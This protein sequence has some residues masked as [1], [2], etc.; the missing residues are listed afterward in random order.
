LAELLLLVVPAA[1][2]CKWPLTLVLA[3]PALVCYLAVR[4]T[5]AQGVSIFYC[6]ALPAIWFCTTLVSWEH[7]GDEY[8]LFGVGALPA[9]WAMPFVQF[10]HLR[11]VLPL[12]LAAGVLTM[13]LAGWA[14]DRMRVSLP[15]WANAWVLGV[16]LLTCYAVLQ[17]PSYQR[18]MAK[19]GSLTAYV[20]SAI[21][22]SLYLAALGSFLMTPTFRAI[23]T[24]LGRHRLDPSQTA[25]DAP[26]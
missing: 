17:Y 4:L 18:A 16:I 24:F 11:E 26:Q 9:A 20:S 3:V 1:I 6:C 22:I 25:A 19:N 10:Q 12:L 5:E 13:L 15:L 7:P 21:N 2:V 14:M 8:G 23:R